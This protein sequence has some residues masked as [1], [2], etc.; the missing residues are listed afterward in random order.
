MWATRRDHAS[1]LRAGPVWGPAPMTLGHEMLPT[2]EDGRSSMSKGD[3][4]VHHHPRSIGATRRPAS[5]GASVHP[6]RLPHAGAPHVPARARRCSAS[7]PRPRPWPNSACVRSASCGL[8]WRNASCHAVSSSSR[9]SSARSIG[10]S[11]SASAQAA[12]SA[13]WWAASRYAR[14][15]GC[16]PRPRAAGR[17]PATAAGRAD[18]RVAVRPVSTPGRRGRAPSAASA[19]LPFGSTM[20]TGMLSAVASTSSCR[21]VVFPSQARRTR[22]RGARA[23]E[24]SG[25]RVLVADV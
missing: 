22:R 15:S 17:A 2:L 5:P 23:R 10:W 13:R 7:A 9:R 20:T 16:S 3:S 12:H 21:N 14:A 11:C 18:R 24:L 4:D 1:Q 8:P 25:A 19:G 6:R